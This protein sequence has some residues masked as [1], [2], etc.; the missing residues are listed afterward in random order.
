VD[1]RLTKK[2]ITQCLFNNNTI[3]KI[4]VIG[5]QAFVV[6]IIVQVEVKNAHGINDGKKKHQLLDRIIHLKLLPGSKMF[7]KMTVF[8]NNSNRHTCNS[9]LDNL[10]FSYHIHAGSTHIHCAY[11]SLLSYVFA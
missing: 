11:A 7:F 6:V 10:E 1:K 9:K 5:A 8:L 4:P 3:N 2:V